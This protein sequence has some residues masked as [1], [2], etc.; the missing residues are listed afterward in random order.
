MNKNRQSAFGI[1]KVLVNGSL[2][3]VSA[4]ISFVAFGAIRQ[5]PEIIVS[6][7]VIDFGDVE[8]MQQLN[9][10]FTVS[11]N[12]D[13]P[14]ELS[15]FKAS[16]GCINVTMQRQEKWSPV[17]DRVTLQT[18]E[19]VVFHTGMTSGTIQ[20]ELDRTVVF[21]T[22]SP[23]MPLV[24][25]EMKANLFGRLHAIP[26][27]LNLGT[28]KRGTIATGKVILT[29]GGRITPFVLGRIDV[30]NDGFSVKV[31]DA[32]DAVVDGKPLHQLTVAFDGLVAGDAHTTIKVFE[33]SAKYPLITIPVLVR[34]ISALS[35]KPSAIVFPLA[36]ADNPYEIN[37]T[38]SSLDGENV[39]FTIE[40]E[41]LPEWLAV[42]PDE[43]APVVKIRARCPAKSDPLQ[44]VVRL[45]PQ[46][47]GLDS[48][49]VELSVF[50]VPAVA[51]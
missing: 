49:A 48:E 30:E 13:R 44:A 2:I 29:D 51:K 23:K 43:V 15:K 14:L 6:P 17:P 28:I 25:F 41:S 19:S 26:S 22:D 42:T 47:R 39:P 10:E 7:L 45:K 32:A 46:A 36:G 1:Q 38:L 20:G 18:G 8:H 24:T 3:L 11:N 4:I 50:C 27:S 9:A 21:Q 31:E 40:P 35:P 34:C 16:C 5:S 37:V 12:S 33:E